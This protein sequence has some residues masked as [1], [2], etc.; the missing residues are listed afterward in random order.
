MKIIITLFFAMCS[1]CLFAQIKQT[2]HRTFVAEDITQV[3]LNLG[4]ANIEIRETKG[5]RV[6][7]EITIGADVPSEAMMNFLIENKRYDLEQELNA[8]T[9]TL[10][11]SSKKNLNVLMVKGKECKEELSYVIYLPMKIKHAGSESSSSKN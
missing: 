8:Q 5:S 2:I 6:L 10:I 7:V 11:L 1:C 3:Q 9:S 4:T